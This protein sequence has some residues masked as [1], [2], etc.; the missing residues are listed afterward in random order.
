MLSSQR[1]LQIA[2]RDVIN[3]LFEQRETDMEAF[4]KAMLPHI[5]SKKRKM[6]DECAEL[7]FNNKGKSSMFKTLLSVIHDTEISKQV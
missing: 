1:V 6:I 3:F 7:L 4:I 5:K 2:N